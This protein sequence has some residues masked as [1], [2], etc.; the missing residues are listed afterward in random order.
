MHGRN[1]GAVA[2]N[3]VAE[4]QGTLGPVLK[5]LLCYT[6]ALHAVAP[7]IA[8]FDGFTNDKLYI[9]F[10]PGCKR[11]ESS[12][13]ETASLVYG[14]LYGLRGHAAQTTNQSTSGGE[15]ESPVEASGAAPHAVIL[16]TAHEHQQ[17]EFETFAMCSGLASIIFFRRPA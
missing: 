8:T 7:L 5:L 6:A 1:N 9:P 14:S 11:Q 4:E 12:L 10:G 15:V 3:I 2:V 17:C 13:T 16:A